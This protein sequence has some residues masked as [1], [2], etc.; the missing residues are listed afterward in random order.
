MVATCY[1][2]ATFFLMAQQHAGELRALVVAAPA[3]SVTIGRSLT[4]IADERA[5][6]VAE[7]AAVT[8]QRCTGGCGAARVRRATLA[9][10]IDALDVEATE[11][12]RR[13]AAEDRL[14][15][16]QDRAAQLR[17]AMR[18]DVVTSR[19]AALLG[20][21]AARVDLLSGLAFAAVLEGVACFAWV[22]TFEESRNRVWS[23]PQPSEARLEPAVT[24]SV[25]PPVTA[26]VT[27][28]EESSA[29]VTRVREAITAGRLRGTVAEIRKHLGCSQ[30]RAMEV[31]RQLAS[32]MSGGADPFTE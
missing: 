21:P 6:T 32:A 22:L 24:E 5:V 1:G 28:P 23:A 31:R 7:L 16:Q 9:A 11:A 29:E 10:Q 8:A 26:A 15:V 2:H 14:T 4:H 3:S 25:T 13:E 18:A 20:I 19:V 30:S 12:K 17:D 27:D